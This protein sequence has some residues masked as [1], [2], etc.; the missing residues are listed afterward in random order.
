MDVPGEEALPVEDTTIRLSLSDLFVWMTLTALLC[1]ISQISFYQHLQSGVQEVLSQISILTFFPVGLTTLYLFAKRR[2]TKHPIDFQPGHWLL[3]QCGVVG[4]YYVVAT[5]LIYL[6]NS[7][8]DNTFI[9]LHPRWISLVLFVYQTGQM[10][11]LLWAAWR[12]PVRSP[13]EFYLVL[14]VVGRLLFSWNHF[15]YFNG[16]YQLGLGGLF[17]LQFNVLVSIAEL[18]VLVALAI[19]DAK[20]APRRDWLHWVGVGLFLLSTLLNVVQFG[21]ALA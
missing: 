21:V 6:T 15:A 4:V 17:A 19:W 9:S 14:P 13:W 10:M 2:W 8:F 12:F 1:F 5:A 7:P 11:C 3:V 20:T 18:L 16:L